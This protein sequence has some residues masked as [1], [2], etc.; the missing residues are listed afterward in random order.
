EIFLQLSHLALNTPLGLLGRASGLIF[1]TAFH[2]TE[3]C[4]PIPGEQTGENPQ[5]RSAD[6]SSAWSF[7]TRRTSGVLALVSNTRARRARSSRP[8]RTPFRALTHRI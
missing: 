1:H 5:S 8:L 3:T 7:G 2:N 4:H 6:A